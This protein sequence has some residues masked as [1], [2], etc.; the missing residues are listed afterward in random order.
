MGRVGAAPDE[1]TPAMSHGELKAALGRDVGRRAMIQGLGLGL[2]GIALAP[3]ARAAELTSPQPFFS[4]VGR[5]SNRA[6]A[7]GA[8]A[9][10]GVVVV[11]RVGGK[12]VKSSVHWIDYPSGTVK[13]THEGDGV[14]TYCQPVVSGSDVYVAHSDTV[15]SL[16]SD[17]AVRWTKSHRVVFAGQQVLAVGGGLVLF[18]NTDGDLVALDSASGEVAWSA[19]LVGPHE[20]DRLQMPVVAGVVVVLVHKHLHALR[21]SDGAALW[22]H[23]VGKQVLHRP[24]AGNGLVVFSHDH[25]DLTKSHM[26]ALGR[27]AGTRP[28]GAT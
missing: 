2:A 28:S 8:L 4:F 20:I 22:K 21:L 16:D 3:A 27:R 19:D 9:P 24:T 5:S 6:E 14:T 17:G 10:G 7:A 12:V 18:V 11:D 15:L 1:E 25:D 23:D 13:W 26:Q